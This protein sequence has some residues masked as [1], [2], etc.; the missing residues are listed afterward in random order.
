MLTIS[1]CS[2]FLEDF[3]SAGFAIPSI[4]PKLISTVNVPQDVREN[5]QSR[6]DVIVNHTNVGKKYCMN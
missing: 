3:H 2:Y 5:P 4:L 1:N 6:L